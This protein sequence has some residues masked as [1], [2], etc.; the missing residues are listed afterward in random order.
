MIKRKWGCL[1][2]QVLTSLAR[3]VAQAPAAKQCRAA[4]SGFP[5]GLLFSS[6]T[7]ADSLLGEGATAGGM[8]HVFA[9]GTRPVLAGS[10][11]PVFAW[12]CSLVLLP[13]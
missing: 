11:R 3:Q 12:A 5:D 10:T 7:L 6:L 1:A 4:A 2:F 13:C 9:G 8:C